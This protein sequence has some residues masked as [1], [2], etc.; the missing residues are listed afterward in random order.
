MFK[1]RKTR[2]MTIGT[3][4]VVAVEIAG[5]V[6]PPAAIAAHIIAGGI[7]ALFG[8][9]IRG[10]AAEDAALKSNPSRETVIL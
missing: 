6:Y 10:I 9:N 4:L 5:V 8:L 1:S 2:L 3:V 7:S